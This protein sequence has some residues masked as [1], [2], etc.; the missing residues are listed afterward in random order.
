MSGFYCTR[1]CLV[2]FNLHADE[3]GRAHVRTVGNRLEAIRLFSLKARHVRAG[4]LGER[5]ERA[6][7]SSY[8]T[9]TL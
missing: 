7:G 4:L 6:Q 8:S 3:L 5:I 1:Q 9:S 2:L